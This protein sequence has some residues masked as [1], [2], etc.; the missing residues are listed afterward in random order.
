MEVLEET[1]EAIVSRIQQGYTNE[2]GTLIDRY[3]S[4][5]KRYLEKNI[6]TR[7]DI[8]DILQDVFVKTY[9]NIH[10]FDIQQRFSPW[11]YRIAHNEMVNYIKK[12]K[13][14]PFSW[15]E[16]D[17]LI[18]F[19]Q[20]STDESVLL[21]SDRAYEKERIEKILDKIPPAQREIL[22]LYFYEELSYKEISDV[23]RIPIATVGV[24]L[25]RA[26]KQV[27]QLLQTTNA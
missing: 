19:L 10:R 4:K 1:E 9:T 13:S 3:E 18:P 14:L 26:K 17:V 7:E 15:F 2:I 16:P 12:K 27:E 23:L 22:T 24:R 21:K 6:R 5:L 11:I 8:T 25:T 20:E